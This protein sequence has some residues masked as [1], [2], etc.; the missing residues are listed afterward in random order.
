MHLFGIMYSNLRLIDCINKPKDLI[1]KAIELDPSLLKV[2]EKEKTFEKIKEYI[3]VSVKMDEKEA[4]EREQAFEDEEEEKKSEIMEE[5]EK[6]A[7]AYLEDTLRL[8]EDMSEAFSKQKV[9]EK[10]NS[11]FNKEKNKKETE[12]KEETPAE[13]VET[14]ANPE[15][16]EEKEENEQ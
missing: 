15:K 13:P 9:E 7:R 3:T 14:E 6:K 12:A 16:T 10:V 4:E 5:Q 2:A 8:V 11:I 1:N